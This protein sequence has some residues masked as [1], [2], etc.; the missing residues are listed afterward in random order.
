MHTIEFTVEVLAPRNH[1]DGT[2]DLFLEVSLPF[3][4]VAGMLLKLTPKGYQLKV[5]QV[6]WDVVKGFKVTICYDTAFNFSDFTREG[7]MP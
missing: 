2:V 6:L 7:W 1:P 5:D 4:P 3:V